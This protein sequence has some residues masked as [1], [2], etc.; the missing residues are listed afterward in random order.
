MH[1]IL[2]VAM[3]GALALA[4]S[5]G[6]PAAPPPQSYIQREPGVQQPAAPPKTAEPL[7]SFFGLPVVVTAPV[8]KPYCNCAADLYAGQPMRGRQAVILPT[9]RAQ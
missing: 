9:T 6:A 1:R 7:F 3:A 2:A 8:A 4:G 5:P